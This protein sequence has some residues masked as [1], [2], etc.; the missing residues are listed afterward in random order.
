MPIAAI[1]FDLD[2][3]LVTTDDYHYQ[4]WQRLADEEGIPFDRSMNDRLRG[5]SR[6]ASLEILLEKSSRSYTP[7]EK[8][9]LATRKNGYYRELITQITPKDLLPGTQAFLDRARAKGLKLGIGSSS[10]NA[11][12][13]LEGVGLSTFF[14]VM[15]DG[16]QISQSKP[17]P[18]V[19]LLGAERLGLAPEACLVVEDAEAGVSAALAGNMPVLA[20]GSAAEDPRAT[21]RARDLEA[22]LALPDLPV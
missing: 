17:H 2:G 15:V 18:E 9:A 5:V 7:E 22:A 11:P 10:R 14:D 4:G 3:V 13:I 12:A 20:V 16:N 8:E 21:Y 19:F 6:M 1:L